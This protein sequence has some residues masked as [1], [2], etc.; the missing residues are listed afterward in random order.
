MK[1]VI[2]LLINLL[3]NYL[4]LHKDF[5]NWSKRKKSRWAC[6]LR[7]YPNMYLNENEIWLVNEL[8]DAEFK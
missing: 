8:E 4:G 1:V 3:E 2:I 7:G 5:L 6:I